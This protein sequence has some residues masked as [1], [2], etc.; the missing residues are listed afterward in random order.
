M[1]QTNQRSPW[2]DVDNDGLLDLIN[3][4]DGIDID[5]MVT[6][7]ELSIPEYDSHDDVPESK[8][9]YYVEDSL[10]VY[11]SSKTKLMEIDSE[12]DVSIIG[13]M[14]EEQSLTS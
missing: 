13:E 10:Y 5:K 1:G 14:S 8:G 2:A 4:L 6:Q 11:D 7:G 3:N 9:L 12:G